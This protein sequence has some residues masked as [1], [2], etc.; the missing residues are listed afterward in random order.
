MTTAEA[1]AAAP[2]RLVAVL[3]RVPPVLWVLLLLAVGLRLALWLSYS[4]AVIN[5]ADSGIYEELARGELFGDPTRTVGYPIFLRFLHAISTQLEFTIAAQHLIGIGSG[6]LLY[7]T[8][9]RLGAPVWVAAVAA[10]P[11]LLSLDQ[12]FLEHA[13]MN[14]PLFTLL[15]VFALYASVRALGEERPLRGPLTNRLTWIV[16]AASAITLAGWVRAVAVPVI[17]LFVLWFAVAIAGSWR[18]RLL[19]AGVAT[20]TA[21]A[22]MLSYFALHAAD[23]GYF[24][25]TEAS[26]WALYSRVAP[27]AD[28]EEFEPPAGTRALCEGSSADGR[29]GPDFY[30]YEPASPARR[31]FGGPPEGNEELGAF[32][33][34]ALFAQPFSYLSDVG[35]DLVRYFFP[36]FQPQPFSGVG[37]E[38][39]A[40]D[41]RAPGAE[42]GIAAAMNRYYDFDSYEIDSSVGTLADVQEVLRVQP[43]LLLAAVLLGLIAIP[44]A[45][46]ALRWGVVLLLGTS[47]GLMVVA[48]ATAIWSA[49]YAVPASGPIVAAGTIGAWLLVVRLRDRAR[50]AP[51]PF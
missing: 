44:L 10:A 46:G 29:P 24:G 39:L 27:F 6:L 21:V 19:R 2:G 51:A 16:A 5:L 30:G 38:L 43:K 7:A 15:F 4:P 3:G 9:R 40:I 36:S 23:N 50:P 8:V 32:A 22:L 26:G 20:L 34:R 17:A 41:R 48:P 18:A 31:L 14:E 28:C 25:F 47:L 42:E 45:A 33:R 1:G 12:I 13:L 49:R 11:I 35:R 37:L